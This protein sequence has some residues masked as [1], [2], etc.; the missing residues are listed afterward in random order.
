M[1]TLTAPA[2]CPPWCACRPG[3][4][5]ERSFLH[6]GVIGTVVLNS[7]CPAGCV[8]GH[9][10]HNHNRTGARYG[11]VVEATEDSTPHLWLLSDQEQVRIHGAGLE[12][13]VPRLVAGYR[14]TLLALVKTA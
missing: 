6:T 14:E 5:S 12:P 7:P 10:R 2:D 4:L 11:V 1:T 9:P 8:N 13:Y 3:H